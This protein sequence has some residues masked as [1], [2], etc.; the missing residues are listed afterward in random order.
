MQW[1]WR[2]LSCRSEFLEIR[3]C[4]Q[5]N[6]YATAIFF[7][8]PT[9]IKT[10]LASSRPP[11]SFKPQCK[12][13]CYITSHDCS[14]SRPLQLQQ[15]SSKIHSCEL[16]KTTRR[17]VLPFQGWVIWWCFGTSLGLSRP[18]KREWR[19]RMQILLRQFYRTHLSAPDRRMCQ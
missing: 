12:Q 10:A 3:V 11:T 8:L 9:R 2:A 19:K 4:P 17:A 5:I 7:W 1:S 18:P 13:K 6:Y 15:L 14:Y 16:A